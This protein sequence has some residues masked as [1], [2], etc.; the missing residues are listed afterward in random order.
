MRCDE[1]KE[2]F[3]ELLYS[4]RGTPSA[5]PE[6]RAHIDSCPNCRKELDELKALQGI[7]RNWKDEQPLRP[8]WI[9]EANPVFAPHRFSFFRVVKYAGLAALVVLAFLAVSNAEFTRTAD[10][11]SLRTHAFSRA[12]GPQQ[13]EYVT[14]PEMLRIVKEAVRDSEAYMSETTS[15]QL[16]AALD[17]VDRQM[18][19]EI[20]Y[21]R[22]RYSPSKAGN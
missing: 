1:I 13:D 10:G 19:Q 20:Q 6:L 4:E 7:L 8:I 9:P 14:R 22:S 11:F 12:A 2:R 16:N 15:Q 21:V 3:V 18:G 5:G 17:L